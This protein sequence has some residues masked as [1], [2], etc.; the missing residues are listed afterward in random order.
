V[1]VLVGRCV[2]IQ[3]NSEGKE[4]HHSFWNHT[5]A[6]TDVIPQSRSLLLLHTYKKQVTSVDYQQCFAESFRGCYVAPRIQTPIFFVFDLPLQRR[7]GTLTGPLYSQLR[8]TSGS[9]CGMEISMGKKTSSLL[10][11]GT[12]QLISPLLSLL[13]FQAVLLC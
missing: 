3:I 5:C 7:L 2:E 8:G 10:L 6:Q 11:A 9:G 1:A 12:H 13:N 4:V